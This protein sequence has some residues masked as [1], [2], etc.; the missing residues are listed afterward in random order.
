[1]RVEFR[2]EHSLIPIERGYTQEFDDAH[3]ARDS[4]ERIILGVLN[5]GWFPKSIKID[6]VERLIRIGDSYEVTIEDETR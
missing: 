1:M 6:G 3:I 4:I 5:L 2:V